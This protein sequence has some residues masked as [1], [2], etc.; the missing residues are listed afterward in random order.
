MR[1]TILALGSRGDVQPYVALG[2]GLQRAGHRVRLAATTDYAQLVCDHGLPFAPLVGSI[3]EHMD[4]EIV[5]DALDGG[6]FPL[7]LARRFRD[8][9]APLMNRLMADCHHAAR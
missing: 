8:A 1:V 2:L 7:R 9:V 6:A 3:R 5:Y 4:R